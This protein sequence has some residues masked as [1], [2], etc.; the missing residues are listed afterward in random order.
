MSA[1][2]LVA[3]HL[4]AVVVSKP[5]TYSVYHDWASGS[6]LFGD[7][8]SVTAQPPSDFYHYHWLTNILLALFF[9]QVIHTLPQVSPSDASTTHRTLLHLR[10]SWSSSS[11]LPQTI[12]LSKVKGTYIRPF[13]GQWVQRCDRNKVDIRDVTEESG[14]YPT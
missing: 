5:P 2:L 10:T 14:K 13:V 12:R 11:P 7:P 8:S 1:A 3:G 9:T 4:H 6:F